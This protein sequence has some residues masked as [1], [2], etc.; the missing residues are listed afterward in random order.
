LKNFRTAAKTRFAIICAPRS[1]TLSSNAITSR[2][3]TSW[4]VQ[5]PQT[6]RTS[7][8]KI[9]IVSR[10]VRFCETWR[11]MNSATAHYS[12]KDLS[13]AGAQAADHCSQ[14]VKLLMLLA[15]CAGMGE[16]ALD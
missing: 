11:P 7:R 8:C 1:R 15:H 14:N 3:R 6:G 5:V 10:A 4:I 13:L 12:V 9:R 16:R 2:F